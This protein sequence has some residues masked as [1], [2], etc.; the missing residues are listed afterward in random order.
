MKINLT[1]KQDTFTVDGIRHTAI[2]FKRDAKTLATMIK[3]RLFA[4]TNK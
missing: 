4:A 3:S 1:A 2:D